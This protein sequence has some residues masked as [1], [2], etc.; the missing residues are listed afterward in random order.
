M[1]RMMMAASA[2][3]M[4]TGAAFAGGYT[5]TVT[6]APVPAPA[7]VPVV[8]NDWTGGYVGAQLG[9]GKPDEALTTDGAFGG[10][11][12]GYIQDYGRYAIGGEV[13]YNGADMDSDAAGK[14]KDFTD[15]KL[16]A[17][18]P[19]GKWLPYGTIGASYVRADINGDSK[20]DTLP[21]V[22]VGVKYQL[23]DQW[24]LGAEAAYRKGNGFDGTGEDLNLPT[25]GANVAFRF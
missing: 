24:L 21:M 12:A 7:V 15:V 8:A 14:V 3:A 5:P 6:D 23:N 17:G 25:I 1:K 13:A 19:Y 4:T 11:H 16:I 9:Y 2:L 20:S 22:G 18:V 10:V